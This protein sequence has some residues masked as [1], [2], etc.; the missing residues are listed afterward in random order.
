[1][2]PPLWETHEK[3]RNVIYIKRIG[4]YEQNVHLEHPIDWYFY[5][6]MMKNQYCGFSVIIKL[7][8]YYILSEFLVHVSM[9][10]KNI[11]PPRIFLL[12]ALTLFATENK[13]RCILIR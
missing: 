8:R 13:K 3:N 1:M 9:L 4:T 5:L 7:Y 6:R 10:K 12:S 2:G 11:M